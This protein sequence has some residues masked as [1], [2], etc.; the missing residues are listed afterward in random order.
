M[1]LIPCSRRLAPAGACLCLLFL[2]CLSQLCFA[3]GNNGVLTISP[4]SRLHAKRGQG[5]TQSLTAELQAGFHINSN[6]PADSFL[7]PV[8]LTWV[9][10]PLE[11]EQVIYPKPQFKNYPFSE[12]PVSVFSDKF[13]IVT[14]FKTPASAQPGMALMNG[15]LRYQACNERECLAPKTVDVQFAVDI[16]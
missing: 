9:K 14:K 1:R 7:I 11:A 4:A 16:Q 12:K 15:K 13:E 6:Q 5:I 8:K 3:A 2:L 10:G